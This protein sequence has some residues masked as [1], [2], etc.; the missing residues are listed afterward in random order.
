MTARLAVWEM[1]EQ[2]TASPPKTMPLQRTA[3]TVKLGIYRDEA[4]KAIINERR[5]LT[6]DYVGDWC[7]FGHQTLTLDNQDYLVGAVVDVLS[8]EHRAAFIGIDSPGTT[9]CY[10][11]A[12]ITNLSGESYATDLSAPDDF[13]SSLRHAPLE[14]LGHP[15]YRE[16]VIDLKAAVENFS[17]IGGN[18]LESV[19]G[20]FHKTVLGLTTHHRNLSKPNPHRPEVRNSGMPRKRGKGKS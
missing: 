12:R 19:R 3:V 15:P 11:E 2:W 4:D 16:E 13:F 20:I 5:V 6:L 9:M 8:G 10:F 17:A 18:L 1:L 14:L 7:W